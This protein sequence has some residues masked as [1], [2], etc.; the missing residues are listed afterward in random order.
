VASETSPVLIMLH[1]D[2]MTEDSA[3][4]LSKTNIG[5]LEVDFCITVVVSTNVIRIGQNA[6]N[7]LFQRKAQTP[8]LASHSHLGD[9]TAEYSVQGTVILAVFGHHTGPLE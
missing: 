4:V 3:H 8:N 1:T 6:F 7:R 9:I 2:G 5:D